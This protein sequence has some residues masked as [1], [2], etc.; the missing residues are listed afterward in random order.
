MLK[1]HP[2]MLNLKPFMLIYVQNML[3]LNMFMVTFEGQNR[4]MYKQKRGRYVP[5]LIFKQARTTS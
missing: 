1:I 5:F 2:F 4:C 3:T